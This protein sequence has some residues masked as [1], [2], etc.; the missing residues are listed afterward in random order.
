ME[1]KTKWGFQGNKELSSTAVSVRGVLNKLMRNINEND[2]R[3]VVTLART[4]P[5]AFPCFRTTPFAPNA[6]TDAV[7]SFQFNCYPP[8]VGLASARRAIADYLS[9]NLSY[10]LSP[11][12]VY[13]SVG[14]TQAI[15]IIISVLARPGANILLP[16]PEV[17]HFDLLPENAWEVDL[18][19]VE[20]LADDNTVA[21]VIINPGSPCGNVF[22]RQHLEK[23]AE[24]ARKHG[25]FV[26]SDEA[27]AGQA[28][29]SNPFVPMAEFG[30]IVPVITLGSISKLWMVPGWRL[31]WIV[32]SDSDD[33]LKNTGFVECVNSYLEISTDPPTFLQA[34]LPGIFEKTKNEFFSN[35]LDV[36]RED[37]NICYDRVNEIA[38]LTCPHKPEGSMTVMVRLNLSLLE[39]IKDDMDFCLKLAEEESVTVLP[40]F[41]VGLKNW[42]RITFAIDPASLDDGL[43]RIKA[44][45]KRHAKK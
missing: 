43:R 26:I 28:F 14:G 32:T 39:G 16:R 37:A 3:P 30:S 2:D 15:E 41:V 24:T 19:A 10:Q 25:I 40:G 9:R 8:N 45:Y 20:K 13:L 17:R 18:E 31:G 42:L 38:C 6:I 7:Q 34:A 44:F 5:S 35:I 11:E 33:I 23:I 4:D 29:G 21:M 1:K 27:Y 12:N 22:T 36:L